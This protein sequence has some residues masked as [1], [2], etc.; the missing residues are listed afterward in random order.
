MAANAIQWPVPILPRQVHFTP[1]VQSRSG[2]LSLNG[3]EQVLI[4][5]AGR[6]QAKVVVA[7]RGE[8]S[9]LAMRAFLAQ[10]AGRAGTVL[11]PKWDMFRPVDANGRK[12]SQVHAVDYEDDTSSDGGAFNFDLS[13]LGQIDMPSAQLATSAASGSTEIAITL[14]DGP[15]PQPGHY[16]GIGSRLY[17][18]SHVWQESIGGAT[19]VRFWPRLRSAAPNGAPVIL[20]KPVCLMRFASDDVG[21]DML[22]RR[23]SGSMV[24]ELVE[25]I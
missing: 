5:D 7:L 23:G 25:A 4:S 16:F 2:G 11:V 13:G 17:L 8:S 24:L 15:G 10:M 18:A 20:D 3:S 9:N 14:I 6:W 21:G 19:K 1:A 12:L 22:N